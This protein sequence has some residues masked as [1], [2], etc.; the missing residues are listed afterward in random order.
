MLYELRVENLLLMERAE[1]RL[2]EG[3]NM[4]TGETGAGKT[5]LAHA[6]D[7]LLGGKARRGIVRP[8]APEAYVE[9]VFALPPELAGSERLPAGA[10]EI[11]LARRVWPDGRTRAYVCGRAATVADL[12]D[13]GGGLLA[14]YGQHEHRKLMLQTAQLDVL[15]AYC[16]PD[17]LAARAELRDAYDRT[18]EIE[19]RADELRELA[20]ARER[21]L[22]LVSFELGEIDAADPSVDEEA[23]LGAERDRLRHLETLQGAAAAGADAIA[24]ESGLGISELLAGAVSELERAAEIDPELRGLGE[25]LAGLRYEAEDIGSELRAYR[26]GLTEQGAGP[27]RLQAVEER[28]AVFARLERKHGGDIG[29]VLAHAE[30][31]RER[32]TQLEHA[33]EALQAAETQLADV[34]SARDA[35]AERLAELRRAAAPRLAAAVRERLAELAMADARFE[36]ALTARD[37]GCGPRGADAIEMRIAANPG[38]PLGPLREVASGGELSRVMLALLSVAH[39]EPATEAEAGALLVFDEIDAGIG[40][41]TARAVGEHLRALAAGRQV[42]CITHLPQVAALAQRHFTIAK[43]TRRDPAT[44]TVTTLDGDQVVGELVRMLGA[45]EQDS[46]ASEHARELL[47]AA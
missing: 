21:E 19:H 25:R 44:T 23:A 38:G 17:S 5:L 30:R 16:G 35:I 8:G 32:R 7:L 47:R 9:G 42:L 2:A 27:E 39:G 36:V 46:A 3:L 34:S 31:C 1:L 18:R 4:L 14:F 29:A 20:G 40:G 33:D 24:P 45:A 43:D 13:L 28:L 37:G 10:Q 6:L 11:V 22:D 41:H 15:D 12:Q 26:D